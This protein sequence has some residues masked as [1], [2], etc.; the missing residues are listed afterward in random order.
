MD[1]IQDFDYFYN[2][3]QDIKKKKSKKIKKGKDNKKLSDVD[4]SQKFFEILNDDN[5]DFDIKEIELNRKKLEDLLKDIGKTGERLKK[6]RLL[7]DLNNYKKIV[8]EYLKIFLEYAEKV[9]KKKIW[10]KSKRQKIEKI[11]LQ[12]INNE[13]LELTRIF[14]NE[15]QSTWAIAAKIDKIEGLLIDLMS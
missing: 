11:H 2:P 15:Q 9:E 14:F 7:I 8:K 10:D 1:K 3:L 12:I 4:Q 13:L 5:V 6:S